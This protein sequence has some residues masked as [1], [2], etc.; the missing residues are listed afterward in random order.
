MKKQK[1]LIPLPSFMQEENNK[2]IDKAT[3][4]RDAPKAIFL[5]LAGT[6]IFGYLTFIQYSW[7]SLVATIV[8]LIFAIVWIATYIRL[9]RLKE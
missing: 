2:N 7:F 6:G 1:E 3:V 8:F 5:N 4:W 9:S